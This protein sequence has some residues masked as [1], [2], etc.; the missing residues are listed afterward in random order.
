MIKD[1]YKIKSECFKNNI[2]IYPV[3]YPHNASL[4]QRNPT[5]KIHIE[6]N[7]RV[8]VLDDIYK[9]DNK[10]YYRIDELYIEKYNDYFN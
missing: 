9:Q 8:E 1:I 5:C 6:K 10:L 4:G 7:G 3:P 2:K